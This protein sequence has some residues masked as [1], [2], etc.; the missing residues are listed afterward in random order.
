MHQP[1]KTDVALF[2]GCIWIAEMYRQ[3]AL[4]WHSQGILWIS[5]DGDHRR[6]FWGLQFS[7]GDFFVWKFGKDDDYYLF[8]IFF[9][10]AER[11]SGVASLRRPLN[12]TS[13]GNVSEACS[14]PPTYSTNH[15]KCVSNFLSTWLAI[16]QWFFKQAND[17]ART[18]ILVHRLGPRT[19]ISVLFHKWT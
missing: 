16:R 11:G 5:S 18:P 13:V 10:G 8:I 9:G 2:I 7:T 15:R 1:L 4:N 6:I 19:R 17:M 12:L 3:G 14:R